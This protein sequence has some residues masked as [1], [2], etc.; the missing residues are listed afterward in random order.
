MSNQ[1]FT[2]YDVS[3]IFVW[4]NHYIIGE[5]KNSS[6]SEVTVA[7]GTVVGRIHATGKINPLT[8]TATDGSKW[9]VGIL[10]DEYTIAA[11]ATINVG[12][13][14]SGGVVQDKIVLVLAGDT[15]DTVIDTRQLRDRIA[16]DTL[17]VRLV[18]STELSGTDN[19]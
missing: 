16:S 5:M 8:S 17:G 3:K 7:V 6:A 10:A 2:N 14:V 1:L 12:V 15:L 4:D 11:G 13:C 19:A 9:P 18:P